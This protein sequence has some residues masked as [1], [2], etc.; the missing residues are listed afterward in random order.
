MKRSLTHAQIIEMIIA[1]PP[2]NITKFAREIGCSRRAIANVVRR[3]EAEGVIGP[4]RRDR[5]F[6][7][8]Q[9]LEEVLN[10]TKLK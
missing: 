2:S 10:R 7:W 9:A 3:L 1:N 8:E 6:L 4:R 5:N